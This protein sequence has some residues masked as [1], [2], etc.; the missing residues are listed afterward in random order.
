MV[1]SSRSAPLDR[2]LR[3][4]A[5]GGRSLPARRIDALTVRALSALGIWLF[6]RARGLTAAVC[7]LLTGIGLAALCIALRIVRELRLTRFRNT[8]YARA[9]RT[10]L[11]ETLLLLPE[12]EAERI[13]APLIG[14]G[15]T[16]RLF[17]SKAPVS[18]AELYPALRD[19]APKRAA[20]AS[21]GG[22][23][24]EAIALIGRLEERARILDTEA[25]LRLAR[26]A[27]LSPTRDET[28]RYL[29]A[30]LAPKKRRRPP[31]L[32]LS[33]LAPKYLLLSGLFTV[34]SF[35]TR[36]ALYY[37]MIAALCTSIACVGFAMRRDRPAEP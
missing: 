7:A 30:V 21:V 37:R 29:L 2:A 6:F 11:A 18:A 13:L 23:S 33:S 9:E 1:Y 22:F 10:L 14:D 3:R 16:L 28:E 19:A 5:S 31:S 34:L 27:G 32:F 15:E 35:A 25:V 20:L 24:A 26:D 4:A 17:A 8:Q 12:H 36:Y